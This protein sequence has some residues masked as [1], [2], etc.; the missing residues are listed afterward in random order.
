MS[1]IPPEDRDY[2]QFDYAAL[3]ERLRRVCPMCQSTGPFMHQAGAPTP[4]NGMTAY[5]MTCECGYSDREERFNPAMVEA[6]VNALFY[7]QSMI[8]DGAWLSTQ[9]STIVVEPVV[10]LMPEKPDSLVGLLRIL[11][12]VV[13]E[14]DSDLETA[15]KFM[16]EQSGPGL[17][18]LTTELSLVAGYCQFMATLAY[19]A[20]ADLTWSAETMAGEDKPFT[21]TPKA[22]EQA[23][24]DMNVILSSHGFDIFERATYPTHLPFVKGTLDE[25]QNSGGG[26]VEDGDHG[27]EHGGHQGAD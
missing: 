5:K 17:E 13:E 7:N 8:I 11:A 18:Q 9:A 1:D 27:G 20:I 22:W 25:V 10:P 2:T 6:D 24:E 23:T 12:D 26:A 4:G 19:E 21:V 15:L 16:A 14:R 3:E